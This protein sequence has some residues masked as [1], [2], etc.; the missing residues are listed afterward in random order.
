MSISIYMGKLFK[1]HSTIFAH[2]DLYIFLKAAF[3]L[4]SFHS[5]FQTPYDTYISRDCVEVCLQ[6]L[7]ILHLNFSQEATY[8]ATDT[9]YVTME[10]DLSHASVPNGTE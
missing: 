4:L 2:W 3:P 5:F 1:I 6:N 9:G 10:F 7:D 8:H